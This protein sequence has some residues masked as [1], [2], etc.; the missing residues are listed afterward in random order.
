M[1]GMLSSSSEQ[2]HICGRGGHCGSRRKRDRVVCSVPCPR[3]GKI[4]LFS[5]QIGNGVNLRHVSVICTICYIPGPDFSVLQ[6][7]NLW[8]HHR[9]GATRFGP[10]HDPS[11]FQ[12]VSVEADG[13]DFAAVFLLYGMWRAWTITAWTLPWL[14]PLVTTIQAVFDVE[15]ARFV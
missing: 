6:R 8:G 14:H 15:W 2:G 3:C 11:G 12:L 5:A 1:V 7:V 13:I 9:L 4:S 10:G